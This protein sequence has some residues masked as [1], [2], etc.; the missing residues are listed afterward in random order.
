M[1]LIFKDKTGDTEV[2]GESDN[3]Q[4]LQSIASSHYQGEEVLIWMSS[5]VGK[6]PGEL[7]SLAPCSCEL[8]DGTSYSVG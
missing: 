7:P 6:K 1:E 2:L 3:V 5:I 4:E 8:E